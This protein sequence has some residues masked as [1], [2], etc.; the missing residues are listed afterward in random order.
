MSTTSGDFVNSVREIINRKKTDENRRRIIL[1]EILENILSSFNKS[2]RIEVRNTKDFET[3]EISYSMSLYLDS[4]DIKA[5]FKSTL[6]KSGI[7]L[8]DNHIDNKNSVYL[9][10]FGKNILSNSS[11]DSLCFMELKLTGKYFFSLKLFLK[12]ETLSYRVYDTNYFYLR[13]WVFDGLNF[14]NHEVQIKTADRSKKNM[15]VD[16]DQKY[17]LTISF[18]ELGEITE[19][20]I[21][22]KRGAKRDL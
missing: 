6:E 11:S 9:A 15:K 4:E 10:N 22:K 5:D 17:L 1:R 21:S 2:G 18:D 3:N 16:L 20:N 13:L 12:T 19:T 14:S 8:I 7:N